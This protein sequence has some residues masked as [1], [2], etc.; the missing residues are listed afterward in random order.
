MSKYLSYCIPIVVD[1]LQL[2]ATRIEQRAKFE[3]PLNSRNSILRFVE[4]RRRLIPFILQQ[5]GQNWQSMRDNRRYQM[6]RTD[7]VHCHST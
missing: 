3:S 2:L 1:R 4:Q 6:A 5:F 7:R